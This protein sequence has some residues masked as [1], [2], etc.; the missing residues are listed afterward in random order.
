MNTTSEQRE[1]LS[2]LE[3]CQS[4]TLSQAFIAGDLKLSVTASDAAQGLVKGSYSI[5]TRDMLEPLQILWRAQGQV[6]DYRA[7]TTEIA[8][9][10]A[11]AQAGQTWIYTVQV[12]VTDRWRSI[13]TGA[14]VQI[15]V[16]N[17]GA[18]KGGS[19]KHA[20]KAAKE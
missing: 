18:L 7:R 9:E 3:N 15:F 4:Q 8:F 14:F 11:G 13:V 10:M 1:Y 17:D 12:Q 5:E 16:T 2:L 20:T 6:Q 19:V